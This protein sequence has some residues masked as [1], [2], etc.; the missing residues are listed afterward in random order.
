MYLYVRQILIVVL[1]LYALRVVFNT[2]GVND[3][4]V[5]TVV[6]GFVTLLTF[7]P[8]TMASATQRFFAFALGQADQEKLNKIFS[9]N[10][11]LYGLIAIAIV[12]TLETAGLW[13]VSNQLNLPDERRA[14]AYIL[15]HF[16]IA[17][18][19]LS[20]FSS[21]FMAILIAH[22][23]M[24]WFALISIVEAVLKLAAAISLSYLPFDNLP[25][26]GMLLLGVAGVNTTLYIFIC[27]RKYTE[28]QFRKIYWDTV[29]IKEILGFTG[30]TLLGQ[31]ST[32]ARN[33]A[34]TI[35]LNQ[36]FNPATVAARA[37]AMTV[38]SQVMVFAQNFNTGMYPSIIKTYATDQKK[39]MLNLVTNGSKLTFFLM[40][41]FALPLIIEMENILALWLGA[42]PPA[43]VLFTQLAI[44]EAL[45]MSISLPIA[46]AAR[47]PGKMKLYELTLGSIQ[48]LIFIACWIVLKAGYPAEA[49]FYVAIIA[50]ILMFKV[51]LLLVNKLVS[52]PILPY[53]KQVLFPVLGVVII[54]SLLTII[55]RALLPDG[56]FYSALLIAFS[57][58]V[59]TGCMYYLGLDRLWR[60]KCKT[61]V[62]NRLS[63]VWGA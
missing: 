24:H 39:E 31:V 7:L 37:I 27:L 18:F 52:L 42:P 36:F 15:Y 25:L 21:P 28:C 45:I 46:T 1:N 30:W 44:V 32:V 22:E 5:F 4:G 34:I 19:A 11:L 61:L 12:L 57:M 3:Y 9:V 60:Q 38:A 26:Y 50:N 63:K 14:A 49:V 20:V 35:L 6:A 17:S 56:L 53:Y 29:L 47:A 23:D 43:A 40:W 62:T 59:S 13:Y 55:L 54:S 16:T 41:I 48:L 2:L 33:Q 10:W 8:G 58:F 51:R